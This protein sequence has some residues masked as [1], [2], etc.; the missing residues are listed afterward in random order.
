M[1]MLKHALALAKRG[2]AVLSAQGSL[3]DALDF[4]RLS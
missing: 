3:E 4:P 1:M 2:L